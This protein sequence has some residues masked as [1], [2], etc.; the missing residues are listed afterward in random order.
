[1]IVASLLEF[2]PSPPLERPRLPSNY[3][4]CASGYRRPVDLVIGGGEIA[5]RVLVDSNA[6]CVYAEVAGLYAAQLDEPVTLQ[7]PQIFDYLTYVRE[8]ALTGSP[9]VQKRLQPRERLILS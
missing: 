8:I 7:K 6:V 5:N 2:G 1:M 4:F 3:P 9:R